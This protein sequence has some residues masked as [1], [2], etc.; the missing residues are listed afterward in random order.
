MLRLLLFFLAFGTI[1]TP[2]AQAA[3]ISPIWPFPTSGPYKT[4]QPA[5]PAVGPCDLVICAESYS[6]TRAMSGNYKGPLFQLVRVSDSAVLTI[7]QTVSGAADMTTWSTFCSGVAANCDFG[8]I[9]A[10]IHTDG[11]NDLVPSTFNSGV[12]SNCSAGGITCAAPFRIEAA[13]GLPAI[14]IVAPAGYTLALDTTAEG[15]SGGANSV[16]IEVNGQNILAA[17]TC[18]SVFAISHFW[19]DADVSGTDF[20]L[21]LGYGQP[22][23][24]AWARCST[25]TTYCLGMEQELTGTGADYGSTAPINIIA[26]VNFDSGADATS[27]YF[28][29]SRLF[30][31]PPP[32]SPA[33]NTHIRLGVGADLGQPDPTYLREMLITNTAMSSSDEQAVRCNMTAFYSTLSFPG[34]TGCVVPPPGSPQV[35]PW[36]PA[37]STMTR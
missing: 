33:A 13:T 22:S 4:T 3:R 25:A 1:I 10:Q 18:C 23:N 15:V 12:G 30:D 14:S 9:Y 19:S 11:H 2:D 29:G 31:V 20:G 7:G 27:G 34:S 8:R 17:Q 28:N 26:M 21:V 24:R 5:S 6:V 36:L 35:A 32:A 37:G 16:S